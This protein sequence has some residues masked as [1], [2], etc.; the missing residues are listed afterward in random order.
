MSRTS[1]VQAEWPVE[2]KRDFRIIAREL[3]RVALLFHWW[4]SNLRID[5]IK[6]LYKKIKLQDFGR[7][8]QVFKQVS[9]EAYAARRIKPSLSKQFDWYDK[10]PQADDNNAAVIAKKR[11]V[12]LFYER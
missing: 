1:L 3:S 8:R 6:S 9:A 4:A 10:H 5:S 11:K 7:S 12:N 2:F